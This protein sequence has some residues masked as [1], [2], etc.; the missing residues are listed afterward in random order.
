MDRHELAVLVKIGADVEMDYQNIT[1]HAV[2]FEHR[3]GPVYYASLPGDGD[4]R[5]G[6]RA[7]SAA[8]RKY[9]LSI[10]VHHVVAMDKPRRQYHQWCDRADLTLQVKSDA[11]GRPHLLVGEYPG[12][13]I[14]FSEGC[15]KVF[16]ALC[17]DASDIGIDVASPDEFQ[18]EYPFHRVFDDRELH[19]AL[20]LTGSDMANA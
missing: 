10:L 12:P 1:I 16:A 15:G 2:R 17:G 3:A 19:H 7:N 20:R 13:A 14:S 4:T 5:K 8:D 18:G 11:L 9:L 6:G